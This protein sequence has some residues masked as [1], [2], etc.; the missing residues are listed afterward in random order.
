VSRSLKKKC[1]VWSVGICQVYRIWLHAESGNVMGMRMEKESQD[2]PG[3][4]PAV[5]S[6]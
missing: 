2:A 5:A 1:G 3:T 4:K 6:A